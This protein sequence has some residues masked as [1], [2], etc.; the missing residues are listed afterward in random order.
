MVFWK[1]L[2]PQDDQNGFQQGR[3]Q[4]DLENVQK[5]VL[6]GRRVCGTPGVQFQV[7]RKEGAKNN[8]GGIFISL[9]ERGATGF[10]GDTD[11]TVACRALGDS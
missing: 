6:L 2:S 10:D 11:T 9:K 1:V 5:A 4:R 8:A 7:R 3:R